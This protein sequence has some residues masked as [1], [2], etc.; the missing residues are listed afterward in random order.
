MENGIIN[1]LRN[2]I[3]LHEISNLPKPF[4]VGVHTVARCKTCRFVFSCHCENCQKLPG[5][6]PETVCLC[7]WN[8]E[9]RLERSIYF[10]KKYDQSLESLERFIS[11]SN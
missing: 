8:K 9:Y 11:N 7:G 3:T 5:W 2:N 1:L 10:S 4:D 6:N